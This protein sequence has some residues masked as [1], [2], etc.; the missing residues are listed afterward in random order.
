MV[1]TH[2]VT[3]ADNLSHDLLSIDD[4]YV[5]GGFNILL[6]NPN[7]ESGIPEIF[8]PAT[9][10][11]PAI[12]IPLR[13]DYAKGGFCLGYVLEAD[14]AQHG[15]LL[16]DQQCTRALSASMQSEREVD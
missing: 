5:K 3:T 2:Q 8:K 15:H 1:F 16:R 10:D 9:D 13:H 11:Q 12:S 4:M 14:G 6:R 7:F